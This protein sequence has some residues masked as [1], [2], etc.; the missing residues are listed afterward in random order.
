MMMIHI[1]GL[2]DELL[3]NI[4]SLDKTSAQRCRYSCTESSN[5]IRKELVK[6]FY[7]LIKNVKI[8]RQEINST[9]IYIYRK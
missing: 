4:A 2:R 3:F 5:Y 6:R 1:F 9:R 7:C 8:V